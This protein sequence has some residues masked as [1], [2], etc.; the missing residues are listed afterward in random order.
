MTERAA[1]DVQMVGLL[2]PVGDG[3]ENQLMKD[4]SRKISITLLSD[5]VVL[6]VCLFLIKIHSIQC[7]LL[8]CLLL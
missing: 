1:E 2:L 6:L 8:I 5:K 7:T 4:L 3:T